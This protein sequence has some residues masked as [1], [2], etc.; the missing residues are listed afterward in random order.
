MGDD[1][2]NDALATGSGGGRSRGRR[3]IDGAQGREGELEVGWHVECCVR[4]RTDDDV[5]ATRSE[6]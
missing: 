4:C 6:L 1:L 3:S 2:T 5:E